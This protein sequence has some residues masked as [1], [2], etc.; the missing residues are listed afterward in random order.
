MHAPVLV[1]GACAA[2]DGGEHAQGA[3]W[4]HLQ[5]QVVLLAVHHGALLISILPQAVGGLNE[6]PHA[7]DVVASDDSA[8]ITCQIIRID[9]GLN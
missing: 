3:T 6:F 5:R 1:H 9:G 2:A 8:F 4:E 7:L